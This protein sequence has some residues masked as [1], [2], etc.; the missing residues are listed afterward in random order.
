MDLTGTGVHSCHIV[1]GKVSSHYFENNPGAEEKI[2]GIA[3]TVR[4]ISPEE[5]ANVIASLVKRPKRQVVYP[6]LLQA[7][8][9]MYMLFP[10]ISRWLLRK[11]G[12]TR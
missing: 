7:L 3:K 10:R 1:F 9:W 5:C 4:T 8:V 12:S 11:T 2:P 6:P